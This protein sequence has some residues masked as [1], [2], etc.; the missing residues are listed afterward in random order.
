M[1]KQLRSTKKGEMGKE[2]SK[3]KIA[4]AEM[5]LNGF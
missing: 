5:T 2:Q 4:R 1:P 3:I